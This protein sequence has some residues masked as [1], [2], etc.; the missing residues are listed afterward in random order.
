MLVHGWGPDQPLKCVFVKIIFQRRLHCLIILPRESF[1]SGSWCFRQHCTQAIIRPL[2]YAWTN[3]RG[4]R[5]CSRT[6]SGCQRQ[7]H[8]SATAHRYRGSRTTPPHWVECFLG[9]RPLRRPSNYHSGSSLSCSNCVSP[10][11]RMPSWSHLAHRDNS[12][13]PIAR[14][15]TAPADYD[16]AHVLLCHGGPASTLFGHF[17]LHSFSVFSR[18]LSGPINFYWRFA[19]KSRTTLRS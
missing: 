15:D 10:H 18:L 7:R 19:I 12:T 2:Y 4:V 9:R 13:S 16:T 6:C 17:Q 3:L 1:S 8:A 11:L 14:Y 5:E